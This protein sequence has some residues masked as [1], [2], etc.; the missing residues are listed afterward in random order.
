MNDNDTLQRFLFEHTPIRGE[1][2]HLDATWQAILA[3]HEYPSLVRDILGEAMAAAV[4]LAATLKLHG[5]LVIQIQ[6]SGPISLMVV[7]CANAHELRGLAHWDHL[8]EQG[9]LQS[10]VGNGQLTITLEPDDQKDRYQS[11]VELKGQTLADALMAYLQQSE[12]LDTHLWLAADAKRAAGLLLQKLPTSGEIEDQDAWDRI[13]HLSSTVQKEELLEVDELKL[14]HRLYHEESVRVFEPLPVCFRCSCSRDRVANMLRTLGSEEVHAILE[15]QGEI[16]VAC[17]F[18]NQKYDFDSV[19]VEEL[20][21]T[22][23]PSKSSDTR[24]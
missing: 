2:V 3:R 24:H 4:L 19:D 16:S 8:P 21:A 6:G 20:F 11:I 1:V 5:R 14:L 10:L 7:E 18:C 23:V 17:E 15:E 13:I 22:T 9:D 12:Q